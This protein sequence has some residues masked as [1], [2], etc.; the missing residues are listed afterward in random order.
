MLLVLQS[1]AA[2]G[3]E[4]AVH[5]EPLIAQI[6]GHAALAWCTRFRTPTHCC[7]AEY[8]RNEKH[9]LHLMELLPRPRFELELRCELASGFYSTQPRLPRGQACF[10]IGLNIAWSVTV[11]SI[12]SSLVQ[13]L[14]DPAISAS[15]WQIQIN[16]LLCFAAPN[17]FSS[18]N[19]LDLIY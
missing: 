11:D 19:R 9:N 10:L 14:D 3:V 18:V 6:I 16:R 5:K 1:A 4:V 12:N 2:I 17:H 13:S 15:V 8:S 7:H